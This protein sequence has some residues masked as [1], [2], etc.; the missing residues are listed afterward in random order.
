MRHRG[1]QR[2]GQH[3]ARREQP[4]QRVAD[5]RELLTEAADAVLLTA[6]DGRPG[7][8]GCGHAL[9]RQSQLRGVEAAQ[10]CGVVVDNRVLVQPPHAAHGVHP[11]RVLLRRRSRCAAAEK[12]Q[13]LRQPVG[14]FRLAPHARAQL[15]QQARSDALGV[16]VC[17]QKAR[18]LRFENGRS[19]LPQRA[20][21]HRPH[22]ARAGAQVGAKVAH[23]PQ[24]RAAGVAHEREDLGFHR[25]AGVVIGIA[26]HRRR[27]DRQF[28]PLPVTLPQIGRVHPVCAG[29]RQRGAVLR[30]QHH[31]RDGLAR[32]LT[33][34]EVQ[35]RE[36][37]PLDDLDRRHVD[38]G[39]LADHALHGA[40]AG[41]QHIGHRR[42]ADQF[43]CAHALVQL[44][45]RTAQ[46][47]RV[48]GVELGAVHGVGFLQVAAQGLVRRFQRA[49]QLAVHPCQR[50]EVVAG[51]HVQASGLGVH[52]VLIGLCE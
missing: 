21:V 28:E 33:R 18:C 6:G 22:A 45:A 1:L 26:T 24:R 37:H 4:L 44:C 32:Q 49:A 9:A 11:W 5:Q 46:H 52:G 30:E 13:I 43:E 23:A 7:I 3:F 36:R 27:V 10:A 41:A 2:L 42:Q 40:F 17:A 15:R 19:Q 16:N 8:P 35:Q 50:T 47:R 12:Q 31:R 39:G 34:Q 29:Q 51:Q 38:D 20:Q 48:D 14:H 25:T